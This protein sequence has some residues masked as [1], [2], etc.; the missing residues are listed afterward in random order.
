MGLIDIVDYYGNMFSPFEVTSPEI[1]KDIQ[2]TF[3]D[4]P[5]H[6][7]G[8]TAEI[9]IFF[10]GTMTIVEIVD[11]KKRFD[12]IKGFIGTNSKRKLLW[13]SRILAFI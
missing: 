10:I 4:V 11:L 7:F 2:H 5:L 6:H 13:I 9:L 12:L 1:I 3:G 8:K